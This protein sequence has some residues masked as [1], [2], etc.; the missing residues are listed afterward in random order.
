M[1]IEMVFCLLLAILYSNFS[2]GQDKYL[3]VDGISLRYVEAGEG[4]PVILMHGFGGN[5]DMWLNTDI[6]H[7]L[8]ETFHV[9]AFD[10]RGHGLSD[11]P[12]NPDFYGANMAKDALSLMDYFGYEK[13][14]VVG[15]SMGAR[16]T[17]YLL[18]TYP[19]RLLSATLGASPPRRNWDETQEERARQFIANA[20]EQERNKSPSDT[21]DYRALMAIPNSWESQSI[22]DDQISDNE[23]PTFAIVGSRDP[24]VSGLQDLLA[25]MP[26]MELVII[27]GATHGGEDGLPRRPEFIEKLNNFLI[28]NSDQ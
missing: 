16:L 10:A 23:V 25:V 14:H 1:K 24:R 17:G 5:L 28:A 18:G 27:E 21:Q 3:D 2:F 15:Y 20:Q 7:T 13:A 9:I 12:H 4:V 22:T 8:A 19:E 26:N 6:F 11:K